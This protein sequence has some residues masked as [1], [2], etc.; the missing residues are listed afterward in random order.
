MN[1]YTNQPNAHCQPQ[2]QPH[3]VAAVTG[4]E[5]TCPPPPIPSLFAVSEVHH[6][7]V[8]THAEIEVQPLQPSF[9]FCPPKRTATPPVE[10][11]TLVLEPQVEWYRRYKAL[12]DERAAKEVVVPLFPGLSNRR[13][14]PLGS[15]PRRLPFLDPRSAAIERD[16]THRLVCEILSWLLFFSDLA[17]GKLDRISN[18]VLMLHGRFVNPAIQSH[19]SVQG[20]PRAA[21]K[22]RRMCDLTRDGRSAKS[23]P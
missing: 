4:F 10:P 3:F 16:L 2:Q 22:I 23:Q 20:Y 15:Q 6:E 11:S 7:P 17:N 8:G 1:G 18:A 21:M 12:Q 19:R 13:L 5:P 9:F 14:P